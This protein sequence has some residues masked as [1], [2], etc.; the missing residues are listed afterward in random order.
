MEKEK[1]LCPG[2]MGEVP[3]YLNPEPTVDIIIVI[4]AHG[5]KTIRDGKSGPIL[6][7]QSGSLSQQLGI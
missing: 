6:M 5:G 4:Q 7:Q 1:I 3:V 2:C